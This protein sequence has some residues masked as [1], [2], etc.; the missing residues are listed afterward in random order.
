[1]NEAIERSTCKRGQFSARK[2]AFQ[3]AY[4]LRRKLDLDRRG[5]LSVVLESY[6]LSFTFH[7]S[8]ENSILI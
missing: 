2:E 8:E 5:V 4:L 1:M 3:V 7:L 6:G